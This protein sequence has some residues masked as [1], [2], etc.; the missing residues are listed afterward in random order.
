MLSRKDFSNEFGISKGV[1]ERIENGKNIELHSILRLCDI[2]YLSP[3]ELFYD[4]E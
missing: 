3:K 1:L 4:I 2:F